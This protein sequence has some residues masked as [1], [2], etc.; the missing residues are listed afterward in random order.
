MH[1]EAEGCTAS[2]TAVAYGFECALIQPGIVLDIR[3]E[4][5][6][7]EEVEPEEERPLVR[8]LLEA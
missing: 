2:L 5:D 1:W 3:N 7:R 8:F 4:G 6:G